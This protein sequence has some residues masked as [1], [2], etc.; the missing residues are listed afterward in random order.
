M[1][2]ICH[3]AARD[4]HAE[5]AKLLGLAIKR[6]C[7]GAL[8][9]DQMPDESRAILAL[10]DNLRRWRGCD[11]VILAARTAEFLALM[12]PSDEPSRNELVLDRLLGFAQDDELLAAAG[13][14][15]LI[16]GNRMKDGL[17][18]E[19]APRRRP[20]PALGLAVLLLAFALA[21]QFGADRR[22]LLRRWSEHAPQQLCV[23]LLEPRDLGRQRLD[24]ACLRLDL[25]CLR[26]DLACLRF[27]L[28]A[29]LADEFSQRQRLGAPVDRI[30]GGHP[31]D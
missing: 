28:C 15:S 8:R 3:R 1:K 19:R 30:V 21:P 20:H 10:V 9:R 27:D 25:A 22:H 16:I 7:V 12:H 23:V 6:N 26:L 24:L 18:F 14:S 31:Y 13:A 29:Q 5:S 2:E 4:G 17:C 11:D